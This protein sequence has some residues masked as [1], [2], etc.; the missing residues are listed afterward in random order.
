[1]SADN[2]A[3]LRAALLERKAA[4]AIITSLPNVRYICG[5]TGS[6]AILLVT[7][8]HLTL[9]TDPRYTLQA[10]VETQSVQATV[11]IVRGALEPA[12]GEAL[13][14]FRAVAFENARIRY[15]TLQAIQKGLAKR[16]KLI[17]LD[18]TC[19]TLRMVKSDG[20]IELIRESGV[21]NSQAFA[22][23]LFHFE[24]G[25]TETELAAEIEYRMRRGGAEKAAFD[26]I[27]AFQSNSAL[28]HAHPGSAKIDGTGL[29][30]ID[31]GTL[32]GGYAS[33][34]TR[35]VHLGRP[36]TRARELYRAVLEAQLAAVDRI[37]PGVTTG[38]VDAAAR[39]VLRA[40]G[41]DKAFVHSTGHG[42]GLEIHELPRIGKTDKTRLE[43]GMT[44]TVEPGAYLEGFGG[45]RIEDTVLVT[46]RGCEVLTPTSKDLTVF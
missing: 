42:L 9:F 37:R 41:L 31:M 17:S 2:I 1:M 12:V 21:L 40:H 35:M 22:D 26:T 10:K 8:E 33:D 16:T 18:D 4:A 28:P 6:N 24:R 34:M 3:R 20:E 45:V 44:I 30:L 14:G 5:F 27:V 23:A 25:M 13:I 19:E 39:R 7:A 38:S 11:T 29:L 32:R 46:A 43:P 15:G 36:S